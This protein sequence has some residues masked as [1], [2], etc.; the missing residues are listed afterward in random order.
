MLCT[1]IFIY[2]DEQALQRVLVGLARHYDALLVAERARTRAFV[3]L[4][5]DK[6]VRYG[7]QVRY[8]KEVRTRVFA[9]FLM[10]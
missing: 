3:D 5:M 2:I 4:L 1:Q 8:S 9:N 7:K 6:Q 10:D